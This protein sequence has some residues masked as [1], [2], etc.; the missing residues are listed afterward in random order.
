[1]KFSKHLIL[2][3][4]ILI[5]A[6]VAC[7]DDPD[8]EE[9]VEEDEEEEQV[10]EPPREG[11][12]GLEDA[13]S[14]L[15][16]TR[17][18]DLQHAGDGSDRIFVVEQSGV[19]SVFPND[20]EV[21]EKKVFLNLESKVRDQ[22]NEEGLLG[23]AF[24]PNYA[25]NGYFYVNYSASSPRRTVISR[26]QVSAADAD[27][28]DGASE[29]VLMEIN[30]PFANHNGGQLAFGPDGFLYIASG[31]GGSGGDPQNH[32]QRPETLLGAI[33]R[34]DVDNPENSNNYGIPS[35]NPF[36]NNSE[37]YREEIYAYGLR[38]P[39]RFSFDFETDR[40]WAADVGQNRYEEINLIENGGNYG[41]KTMEGFHCFSPSSDCNREGLQ[42]PIWEYGHSNGDRSV[43]GGYVYRGNNFHQLKGLYIYADFVSGRIWTLDHSDL[44][45]P[46]N[47]ELLRA[48]FPVS[49]FGVD[50]S[51]EL[52]LCG[53]DGNIYKFGFE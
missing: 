2:S 16:F 45:N 10:E 51:N 6:F 52:Y 24:H 43:T 11:P 21:G 33:L 46:V 42:L 39:W 31:D 8:V 5:F 47:T 22:G 28:A 23:L 49:S 36:V 17:P 30:Q 37:G 26:F 9:V 19:I 25:S 40:L 32:G 50:Q 41:W 34:I 4:L 38:N 1:M 7:L 44:E 13:F 15:T 53:F 29:Q 12:I 3:F 27:A 18:V 48:N 20:P 14:Q 35:D